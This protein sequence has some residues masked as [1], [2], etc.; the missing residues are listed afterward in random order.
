M[1]S[2]TRYQLI[3]AALALAALVPP[4][5]SFA[6]DSSEIEN[7]DEKVAALFGRSCTAAGCHSG[8]VPM[9]GLDLTGDNV[10]RTAFDKASTEK[11]DLKIID[12]G[13]AT[14][15]YLV[16]KIKG[17][18]GIV[19]LQM[20]FSGE[21]LTPD[22]IGDIETWIDGLEPGDERKALS[23][24]E[25]A[26]PFYGW[27]VVNLPTTRSLDAGN[28]LFLI[29]HRFNPPVNDGYDSFFGL[30]GSGIIYLSLGYAVTDRLL[31]AVGRSNSEDDVEVQ[32]R[33]A[34][35]RQD[36]QSNMPLGISAQTSFNF[37]TGDL[38]GDDLAGSQRYKAALQ[39]SVTR[40]FGSSIGVA[41]VPGV[42][43]NP[44]HELEGESQLYT[45][46]L[47]GR[48]RFTRNLALVADWAAIVSGYERTRTFGNDI[49]FDTFGAGLEI[50]TAGHVFQII[51]AN[52][53]GLTS[54][55]Y[56]RGGDL[57][58]LEGDMRLG[59]NIFRVLN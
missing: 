41:L 37:I 51:V 58:I 59:F 46:G 55:Q 30:D 26:Y 12:P 43:L 14:T 16:H 32:T 1:T 4:A 27:K 5:T 53:V 29:S 31:V 49:R 38:P 19:G 42:L 8:P 35:T 21:K 24:S 44:G 18:D 25:V 9:L 45:I 52:S 40:Q 36:G 7:L 23:Q 3:I 39:V 28:F 11:P 57:D 50:A 22:E 2:N 34:I 33:Y 17:Q 6:Q 54:D 56:L 10:Y 13:S 48:W 20:P 15:S 47:G